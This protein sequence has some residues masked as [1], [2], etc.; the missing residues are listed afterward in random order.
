MAYPLRTLAEGTPSLRVGWARSDVMARVHHRRNR[1]RMGGHFTRLAGSLRAPLK[2]PLDTS[3][4]RGPIPPLGKQ[5][6][7]RGLKVQTGKGKLS[8]V[9][10][11]AGVDKQTGEV[12]TRPGTAYRGVD[13]VMNR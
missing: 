2:P 5:V 4:G 12:I 6:K 7:D 3:S 10:Q 9:Q 11:E 1:T 13:R 8:T